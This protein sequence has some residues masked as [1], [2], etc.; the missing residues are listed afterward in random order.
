M[1]AAQ[2]ARCGFADLLGFL[3]P[4]RCHSQ[5]EFV[6]SL[7]VFF[8]RRLAHRPL[9][10]EALFALDN[11]NPYAG[12]LASYLGHHRAGHRF[13]FLCADADR[14][15]LPR[16]LGSCLDVAIDLLVAPPFEPNEVT[17]SPLPQQCQVLDCDHSPVPDKD[18]PSQAEAALKIFEHAIKRLGIAQAAIE[19][20]M[21]NRPTIDHHQSDLH[22]RSFRELKDLVE[23]RPIYHHQPKRVRAHIFVATLAF[24][25]T[26]ALEEKPKA[27][28]VPMS[29]AQA[30]EALRTM[31]VVDIRVGAEI[32]RGVTAGNHQARQILATLGINN[33]EPLQPQSSLKMPT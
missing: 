13:L 16:T 12:L 26:R 30:L 31:H 22:L 25:L 23:M 33:R 3:E 9:I 11:K 29:S 15:L 1:V 14:T 24:L 8:H 21:G 32:R 2:D 17:L 6:Q 10:A 19:N 20:V 18:H 27:A 4:T 5:G 7:S 28:A